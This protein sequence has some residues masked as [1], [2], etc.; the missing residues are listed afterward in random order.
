MPNGSPTPKEILA[1]YKNNQYVTSGGRNT[2]G[3]LLDKILPYSGTRVRDTILNAAKIGNVDPSL[4]Y[5][6]AMEE[7]LG[8]AINRPDDVSENYERWARKNS[9]LSQQFPV[10]G[11]YNYGLDT[12][13]VNYEN[14]SKKGYLPKDFDKR[15]TAFDATNEKGQK[16]K[17]AAFASDQ[18]ALIA[19]AAMIRDTQDQLNTYTTNK[20]LNLSQRQRDFFTLAGYN[21]GIGNMQKMIESYNKKGYLK[22]DKFLDANFKPASYGDIYTNVQRRLQNRD[23][24]NNEGFFKMGGVIEKYPDGGEIDPATGLPIIKVRQTPNQQ[25]IW[26]VQ[27][28]TDFP[29]NQNNTQSQYRTD[30]R[31]STGQNV[32]GI[33]PLSQFYDQSTDLAGYQ[34]LN[35]S[36]RYVNEQGQVQTQNGLQD[37]VTNVNQENSNRASNMQRI[38]KIAGIGIAGL[39]NFLGNRQTAQQD[40][41]NIRKAIIGESF[42]TIFNPYSR[43]TGSQAIYKDGGSIHIKKENRGKFTAAA[44]RAGKS[45]QQYAAQIMANPENYSPT[46]RKRANFARNA[47]KFKHEDGG[48]IDGIDQNIQTIDGG[49]VKLV[50][51]SYNSNPFVEFTGKEHNEGGI[52]IV[53]GGEVA[54]VEDKE[55]GFIDSEGSLNIFGKLKVPGTNKTFRKAAKDL[56][57]EEEKV[58]N[59]ISL[60]L[61]T[62]NNGDNTDPYQ[63]SAISTAKIMFKSLDKQS[64]E[65]NQTKEAVADYQNLILS[66]VNNRDKMNYGGKLPK[67]K[68]GSYYE[69]GG[70]IDPNDPIILRIAEAIGQ[71]ESGAD[72]NSRGPIVTKGQYKGQ[73]ALGKY[74]IMPGNLKEWSKQALGK[75]ITEKEFLNN[76]EYQD[77]IARYQMSKLYDKYNNPEDVASAWFTGGP[78]SKGANKKDDVGTS[79]NK[80]VSSVMNIMNR[81]P[82]PTTGVVSYSNNSAISTP[83]GPTYQ[84]YREGNKNMS[85]NRFNNLLNSNNINLST[86]DF[87]SNDVNTP[88][89]AARRNASPL[90][91][92]PVINNTQQQRGPLSPLSIGQIAPELISLATNRVEPVPSYS[93]SPELKQSVDVS[94]QAQRN[95]NQST[96]NT[97]AKIAESTGNIDALSQFA[98]QKYNADQQAT[99]QEIQTNLQNTVQT[100]NA[101][102]DTLNDARLKNLALIA[103]QQT[104]QAQARFNTRKENMTA[105]SSISA[106]TLQNQLENRTYNAYANL[107]KNYG[108]DKY[109]N[110]T[111][112]PG[113]VTQKFNEGEAVQFGMLQATKGAQSI[114]NGD[115]SRKFTKV[116]NDDG[117]TTTTETF[118][119]NQQIQSDYKALKAQG[120]DDDLIGNM[121][122]AKYPKTVNQ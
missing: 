71:F 68:K 38:E 65:I 23:V 66:M 18:D 34:T 48:E 79:G 98:A 10:D 13:G 106:K 56:A 3:S 119:T 117:S 36:G 91:G 42:D 53:Y 5:T 109:G 28:N 11:F 104:K 24:L 122:R 107:F 6:S 41:S 121:L 75:E 80:Y 8:Y 63:Q 67:K 59:N 103:D 46:L 44:K 60:Y 69:D 9:S 110:V 16:V 64:K 73:R 101:N 21:G 62:L 43:G 105:V 88:Y 83:T 78:A 96:F 25:D 94:Y 82:D 32:E 111:F 27:D 52:G 7:G 76:K 17:S 97:L 50:S 112:D 12:F 102:V 39:N 1:K 19:K 70:E 15:F 31:Q 4:L 116:K 93:Y 86:T 89:G 22:D 114:M 58:N 49:K 87:T 81:L 115:F 108:F 26:G 47:A 100:Y 20:K 120:F 55:L 2:W 30:P 77:S 84:D 35:P 51:H 118:G 90:E 92:E 61:K 74:Q 14:L 37:Q 45:V 95:Q 40:R 99:N 57:K 113:K 29:V 72:Y 85:G 33:V 54:E